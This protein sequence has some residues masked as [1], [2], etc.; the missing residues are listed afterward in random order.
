MALP[1][2]EIDFEDEKRHDY[3]G[4]GTIGVYPVF[5]NE[6]L[7]MES[8]RRRARGAEGV[9]VSALLNEWI[10]AQLAHVN[11]PPASSDR[12]ALSAAAV[13]N[14]DTAVRL[15]AR[16][17][18]NEEIGFSE[19]GIGDEAK[20]LARLAAAGFCDIGEL[21]MRITPRGRGFIRVIEQ[22]LT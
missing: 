15:L 16:S 5:G 8:V 9:V 4:W 2:T 3:G 12:L 1:K 13:L 20:A 18:E 17:Y 7:W 10:A 22:G 6:Q 21:K 11:S 14:D 19:L